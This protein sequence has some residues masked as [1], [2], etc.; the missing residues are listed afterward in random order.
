MSSE[1]EDYYQ[2]LG[3]PRNVE[4]N[5][6]KKAYHRLALKYHPDRN[7]NQT[8]KSATQFKRIS[9]AYTVLSDATRRRTYD[10]F[11][12][13]G[14][15]NAGFS[16]MSVSPLEIFENLFSGDL[17][18]FGGSMPGVVFMG[19]SVQVTQS[20]GG[21]ARP[22]S[23]VVSCTL[24]E[25]AMGS[26]KEIKIK[27][28]VHHQG[29]LVETTVPLYITVPKG[30]QNRQLT[31]LE[32]KGHASLE[33]RAGDV[34]ITWKTEK[35][36][37]FRREGSD[38]HLRKTILLSE[39]LLGWT[40]VLR[41]PSGKRFRL[42]CCK[43]ITPGT[44]HVLRGMG[45]PRNTSPDESG[46]LYIRYRMLFPETIDESRA[47]LLGRLLPRRKPLPEKAKAYPLQLLEECIV[48]D[49]DDSDGS[50]DDEVD[51]QMPFALPDISGLLGSLGGLGGVLGGG[52]G[53]GAGGGPSAGLGGLS[54]LMGG[55][56]PGNAGG[57][58]Q[59]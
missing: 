13:T 55:G 47:Q 54:S 15:Q 48:V 32:G 17:A 30:V 16:A 31:T 23:T 6:L 40:S 1:G 10:Q 8:E 46:D 25:I 39:A 28:R 24:E 42:Q 41:H 45:L 35:H 52:V 3:V 27:K 53:G 44:L 20:R 26:N 49:S 22:L 58:A 51:S 4:S 37:T 50:E 38:L 9:E 14:L 43:V 33:G 57:C 56:A 36:S 2:I 19:G 5:S 59:Q 18:T 21:T 7:P 29:R 11:G 34:D 12:S